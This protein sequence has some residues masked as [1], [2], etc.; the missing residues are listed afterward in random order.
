MVHRQTRL[1]SP[2]VSFWCSSSVRYLTLL[3]LLSNSG[4]GHTE[5]LSS[6]HWVLFNTTCARCHEA[7]CSGRLSLGQDDARS[8]AHVER[9]AGRLTDD[10]HQQLF[11][12]LQHMKEFCGFAAIAPG[13]ESRAVW[14]EAQLA[15]FHSPNGD[16]YFVPLGELGVGK[17]RLQVRLTGGDWSAQIVSSSFDVM[18]ESTSCGAGEEFGLD[19]N[20][21][22]GMHYLR[23]MGRKTLQVHELRLG[24]THR[25][26]H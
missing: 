13:V 7:Q 10:L 19:F 20:S 3:L 18:A 12:Y 26:T 17:H 24:T 1:S 22:G 15:S 21:S 14:S 8:R 2:F 25:E 11:T 4:S 23:I 6:R 16:A 9:Y 5:S